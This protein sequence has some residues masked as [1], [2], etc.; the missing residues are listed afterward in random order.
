M[1]ENAGVGGGG[2]KVSISKPSKRRNKDNK[3]L[4]QHCLEKYWFWKDDGKRS[5]HYHPLA[6]DIFERQLARLD[7]SKEWRM[8]LNIGS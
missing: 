1:H 2:S 3:Q 8:Q 5:Y 7:D 6:L 4:I